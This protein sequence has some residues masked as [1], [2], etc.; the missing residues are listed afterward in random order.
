MSFWS[1][2]EARYGIQIVQRKK[3]RDVYRLKTSSHG[4]LCLKSYAIPEDEMRFIAQVFQYLSASGFEKSPKVLLTVDQAYWITRDHVHYMLTDWVIGNA[5][6][7]TSRSD[8]KKTVR[9]LARF[10]SRSIGF[11]EGNVPE[12]RI[13]YG[14]MAERI[15]EYQ[16][17]LLKFKEMERLVSLCDI[18]L[19]D[20]KQPG[21]VKAI[22][23]EQELRTFVHGDYN[24][25]NL[26]KDNSGKLQMIDFENTS[27]HIRM[28]DVSHL[29]H[30]NFPW[31]AD[32]MIHWIEY[33]DSKRTLTKEEKLLLRLLLLV[34]YPVVR[35]LRRSSMKELELTLPSQVQLGIYMRKLDA[36]L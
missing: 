28:Q 2:M 10:H 15:T 13:R 25:P 18:V 31:Q 4:Y 3:I 8:F 5:P 34:P 21:V 35:L 6:D 27:L 17:T 19:S 20:L 36:L 30:R 22:E 29:L 26:V 24:Y 14:K 9:T 16:D 33:Y 12:S 11:P 23:R 1:E 7:M 32:R